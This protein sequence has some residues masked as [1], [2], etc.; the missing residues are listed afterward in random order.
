MFRF[1]T[2]PTPQKMFIE[3]LNVCTVGRFGVSLASNSR[4]PIKYLSLDNQT[5]Q[6]RPAL[7]NINSV[8]LFFIHLLLVLIGDG[9]C[10]TIDGL[11]A[12]VCV[13][14]K[15]K[16]MNVKV[17]NLVSGVSATRFFSSVI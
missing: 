8:K 12:R 11:Y 17:P 4:K 3:L 5:C 10:K 9:S 6:A 13:P 15:V 14:N 16:N 2:H 1:I 7:V